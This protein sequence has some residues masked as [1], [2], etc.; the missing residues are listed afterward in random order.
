MHCCSAQCIN[1]AMSNSEIAPVIAAIV[2]TL[3]EPYTDFLARL[4]AAGRITAQELDEVNAAVHKRK[5][6]LAESAREF[7]HGTDWSLS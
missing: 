4:Q 7:M 3:V 6:G 2:E 5:E 1:A